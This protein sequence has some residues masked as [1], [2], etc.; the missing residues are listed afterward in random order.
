[1]KISVIIPTYKPKDYLWECLDSLVSQTFPHE[2]FELVVVLNGCKEP[3]YTAIQD[4]IQIHGSVHWRFIQTDQ[5]GVSN[6]RNLALDAAQ[7][8]YIAFIDDDDYVSPRYLE[9]LYEKAS[10]DV[11]PLCYPLSF[12]DGSQ[13]FEPYY[14]TAQYQECSGKCR[15]VKA[16]RFF[17]GPV[18]KLISKDVIGQRRFDRRFKNG[19]DSLFMFLISDGFK[20]VDFTSKEAVYYRRIRH[21]S[22]ST[23]QRICFRSIW[24]E[25]KRDWVLTKIFFRHP[26]SYKFSFYLVNLRGSIHVMLELMGK[27]IRRKS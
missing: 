3:F 15:F 27:W 4:Y 2:D 23:S 17:A 22:A 10:R 26:F 13:H 25:M 7:G 5:G 18:Y 8:E 16:R 12:I 21:N 14:I 19:E 20:Y 9:L 1:M 11:I 24:N 6:A